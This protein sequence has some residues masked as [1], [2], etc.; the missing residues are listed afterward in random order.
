MSV[1][2]RER[3]VR[4]AKEEFALRGYHGTQISHI[5]KRAG[6]ARGTFY[7]YFKSKE[8]LFKELL[9]G[10][11]EDLRSLIK[12]VDP[13]RDP[14]PQVEENLRRVIDYALKNEELARIILYRACEPEFAEPLQSF[15]SELTSMV[16]KSLERGMNMGLLREHDP[17]VVAAVVI[18]GVKEVVKELLEGSKR[19]PKEVAK[20]LIEFSAGGLWR[21][22][23]RS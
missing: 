8:E 13:L 2:T 10:V 16:K 21:A 18:G 9:K 17:E 23:S 12:P 7:L 3:I 11:I 15:F 14:L 6:V 22:Q 5:V 20:K 19:E 1:Q 4:A